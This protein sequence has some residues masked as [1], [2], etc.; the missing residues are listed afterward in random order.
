M[1]AA[2]WTA[3]L[4][5]AEADLARGD[6]VRAQTRAETLLSV[7]VPGTA[8]AS[9]LVVA[10]DAALGLGGSAVATVRYGEV[11]TR[12]E[13]APVTPRAALGLG[14]AQLREGQRSHAAQS[15]IALADKFPADARAPMALALAAEVANGAGDP[16]RARALLDRVIA[17]Y[18][19]SPW[20][21][22]ARLGRAIALLRGDREDDGV[23]E[24]AMVIRNAGIAAIAERER[25]ITALT[26]PGG[27]RALGAA[28]V[29]APAARGDG[30]PLS[31]RD[32]LERFATAFLQTSDRAG[33]PYVLHGLVVL[34]ATSQG[35]ADPLVGTLARRLSDEFRH[36]PALPLLARVAAEARAA[37][38]WTVARGA[39]ASLIAHDPHG[40]LARGVRLDFAEALLRTGDAREARRQLAQAG[41]AGET[42]RALLLRMEIAEKLGDRTDLLQAYDRLLEAHPAL[43]RPPILVAYAR[44][45][46]ETGQPARARSLWQRVV[47]ESSGETAAEAAYRVARLA[48]AAGEH[49]SAVEW[50]LTAAYAARGS[51][52]ARWA[53]LGAGDSMAALRDTASALAMYT[54]VVPPRLSEVGD[55]RDAVG[56]A[57]YRAAEIL[58]GTGRH[59][60]AVDMYLTAAHLVAGSGTERRALVGAV[61]CLV[62]IG[63]RASAEGI[64]R[65]LLSSGTAEPEHLAA[66]RRALAASGH[67]APRQR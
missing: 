41:A 10:G 31:E 16:A 58:R 18:P 45:L 67:G 20:A 3:E 43:V 46:E 24:L 50:Y 38:Q 63:D 13:R 15:W 29:G 12:H 14:W 17:R 42:P 22:G 55:D 32:T 54:K 21:D 36:R 7:K 40:P 48:G 9:A 47:A 65:R 1:S 27:E 39:Y 19:G 51:G 2:A 62:A 35:W 57:A 23:R 11:L 5:R 37:G 4:A 64:Y 26:T 28:T 49:E 61:R 53:L 6:L 30:A 56:E 59:A 60:E 33:A 52:W 34:G 44:L 66:A 8:Y 25:L